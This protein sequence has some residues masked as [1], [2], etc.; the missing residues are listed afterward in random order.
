MVTVV[1]LH[2]PNAGYLQNIRTFLGRLLGNVWEIEADSE[3][4]SNLVPVPLRLGA[5]S[6]LILHQSNNDQE[7][8]IFTFS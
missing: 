5:E 2:Y 6:W 8:L 7:L 3:K 1:L 4:V